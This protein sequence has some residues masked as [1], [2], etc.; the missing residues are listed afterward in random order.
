MNYPIVEKIKS[1][2]LQQKEALMFNDDLKTYHKIRNEIIRIKNTKKYTFEKCQQKAN[3]TGENYYAIQTVGEEKKSWY[4]SS[5][6]DLYTDTN[7]LFFRAG[8]INSMKR[9]IPNK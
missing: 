6:A 2:Q 5:E 8:N 4:Y 7:Q 1:L 9:I 3:D